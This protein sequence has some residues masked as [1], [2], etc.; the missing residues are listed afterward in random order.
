[1]ASFSRF[2]DANTSRMIKHKQYLLL[3]SLN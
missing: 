3:L 1:M 2:D